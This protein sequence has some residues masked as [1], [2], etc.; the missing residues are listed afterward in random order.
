MPTRAKRGVYISE[1]LLENVK[2]FKGC[3]NLDL[4]D[5]NGVPAPWTLILGDNGVG[6]TTLLQ[7]VAFM[8]PTLNVA[9]VDYLNIKASEAQLDTQEAFAVEPWAAPEVSTTE[10]F[11]RWGNVHVE[12]RGHFVA[13][14]VLGQLSNED[15]K[16]STWIKF[17]RVRSTTADFEASALEPTPFE[18]EPLVLGYGAGRHMEVGNF[19]PADGPNA[20]ET[21]FEGASPLLDVEELLQHLEYAALKSKATSAK[22]VATP[23]RAERKYAIVRKMVAA[24]L[25]DVGKSSHIKIYG[26]EPTENK[27]GVWFK[28]PYGEVAFRDLS[29]GYQTMAAWLCDIA[30]RL[31]QKYPESE[32]PLREPAIVLVDEIDLHLHPIWQRQLRQ[33]LLEYFPAVQFIATAHSPLMAQASIGANL[34]VVRRDQDT[35]EIINDPY[36][37]Q[38][39]RLDQVITSDLFGLE[40]EWSPYIDKLFEEQRSLVA[41]DNRTNA[42]DERLEQIRLQLMNLETESVED[43]KAMSII[44]RAAAALESDQPKK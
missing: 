35:V 4:T 27:T 13:G 19:D 15:K 1:L 3:H 11:A 37:V 21:V 20:I 17:N 16:F 39:W 31:F 18:V 28:T 44:R 2:P 5:S 29:F 6:K 23:T 25:P 32:N 26:P 14:C 36:V 9:Q 8:A 38:T 42:E 43:E 34:A 40:T 12:M 33:R 22:T 24:L 41:K 7:C 10:R 30:W